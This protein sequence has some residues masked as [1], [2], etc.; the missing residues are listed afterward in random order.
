MLDLRV[1]ISTERTIDLWWRQMRLRLTLLYL[2]VAFALL[3]ISATGHMRLLSEIGHTFGGFYWAIDTDGQVVVVSTPPQL[4]PF[5]ALASSLTSTDHILK[6]NGQQ[7]GAA[8][9]AVY[10]HTP[11]AISS[12][13]PSS[14]T[15]LSQKSSVRR[16]HLP[17]TCG[18]RIIA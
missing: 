10:Q 14:T 11:L 3:L 6:I 2:V 4:P 7:G 5:G 15:T 16:Y 1:S 12:H 17:W 8:M 18:G 13:T 9:T